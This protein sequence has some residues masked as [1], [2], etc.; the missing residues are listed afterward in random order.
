MATLLPQLLSESAA[1]FPHNQVARFQGKSLS[2]ARLEALTNQVARTLADQGVLPGDRVGIYLHK[3]FAS[4]IAVFGILKAGAVYV[5]LD[6]RAPARRLAAIIEDCGVRVLLS[7]E[8]KRKSLAALVQ[9]QMGLE[10]VLMI[11]EGGERDPAN[12]PDSAGN[13]ALQTAGAARGQSSMAGISVLPWRSIQARDPGPVPDPGSAETDLAYILYTSGSTGRPKGVM[14]S[15]RTIFT[16][17]DWCRQTFQLTPQDRAT[18]HAPLHFD[19]ST[20]DIF[21]TV[22]AG[23]TIV[24]IPESTSVFPYQLAKL[25]AEEQ[26]SVIYMVPSSLS[27]MVSHG[28][29]AEH[30]WPAMRL[31]LFAG[32]VFPI[33]FLRQLVEHVPGADFYNLYGPTETNVCTYYR[34]RPQD[35]DPRETRPVPIGVACENMEVFALDA[36]GKRVSSPGQTGELWVAGPGVAQGYWGDPQRTAERFVPHPLQE[37]S[38]EVVYRTG[39]RVLLDEH[40]LNWRFVGRSDQMIKSRGYRIEL[41]EIEAALY[42]HAGVKEAAVIAVPDELVGS[43]LKAFVVPAPGTELAAA[44]LQQHCREL[45]PAYMVPE[46]VTILEV[47]PKTSTGKVNRLELIRSAG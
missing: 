41:G 7:A 36:Q 5:P 15:H 4:L 31:I 40:G 39:D 16:F 22:Q 27:L 42:A 20:F 12:T 29:L 25:L 28:K 45:L 47:L 19:L 35:L 21:V 6:P 23:G 17:I 37:S 33:K 44:Q 32:E 30:D 3:S 13:G 43:R 10:I 24:L 14:I 38:T 9:V 18:S 1:R 2:Y 46:T 8:N 11:G 26:V 34:V